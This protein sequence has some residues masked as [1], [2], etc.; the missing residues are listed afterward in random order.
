MIAIGLLALTLVSCAVDPS[1][2][3]LSSSTPSTAGTPL[4]SPTIT[5][6]SPSTPS[7]T[8][9]AKTATVVLS[10]DLLWHS[11]L[12]ISAET[13]A[14]A[15]QKYDFDPMFAAMK[16]IISGA[17]MA[18]CHSEVPFALAGHAPTGWPI[19][20]APREIAPWIKTMG[21]DLCSTASNHSL[22][23]GFQGLSDTLDLYDQAGVLHTG[24]FR[25]A[26]ER[27]KPV[28]FTTSSGVKIG[29]VTG[30]YGT[31]GIP[32]PE[33]KPWSVSL[34]NADNLLAQ[35]KA[36]RAAGADVVIA[37]MHGGDE[38]QT[39][40]NS[41]Q[42]ALAEALTASPD[43]DVVVGEHVHVV[44]PVTKVNG[45]WVVYGM[46]NLVAQHE[47]DVPR[48]YEGITMRFTFTGSEPGKYTVSK[49]EYIPT[50]VTHYDGPDAPV[51]LY[52]VNASLAAG[53]GP[54]AR[55]QTALARTRDAVNLL[56]TAPDL[57]ES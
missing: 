49:A 24:T 11:T 28:I 15:G 33:G 44:Q 42:V 43:V 18:V 53:I 46:G 55:L 16:P 27:T 6:P 37:K 35:A 25:S 47:T 2:T 26:E 40:P 52:P 3:A 4:A 29:V 5:S 31:N 14:K 30:T 34:W 8:R 9:V 13:E 41:E 21:W 32:L 45:K 54:T 1:T 7:P 50:L 39:V 17:D 48:G 51:R 23:Q 38:Y 19:F 22:D 10:G 20:G 36:T 12:W 57:V 56:G